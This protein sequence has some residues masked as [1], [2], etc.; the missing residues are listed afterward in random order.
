[1]PSFIV[2]PLR[3]DFNVAFDAPSLP[4]SL[5]SLRFSDIRTGSLIR[6]FAS[7]FS[8]SWRR[9]TG[10]HALEMGRPNSRPAPRMKSVARNFG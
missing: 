2:I 8:R 4:K 7:A 1:M 5:F 10:F 3:H 9:N 6:S